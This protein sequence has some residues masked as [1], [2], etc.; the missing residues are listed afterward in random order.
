MYI[1][2]NW[3]NIV[4]TYDGEYDEPLERRPPDHPHGRPPQRVRPRQQ[5][6]RGRQLRRAL[7]PG[8]RLAA[9]HDC[10]VVPAGDQRGTMVAKV[11]R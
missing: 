6:Q 7:D 10:E 2:I 11:C 4:F 5:E 3:F 8:H 1:L 9:D